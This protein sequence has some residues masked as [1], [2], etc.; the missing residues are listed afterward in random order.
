MT[1][2][3]EIQVHYYYRLGSYKDSTQ[4]VVVVTEIRPEDNAFYDDHQDGGWFTLS[5][6]VFKYVDPAHAREHGIG[7]ESSEYAR[8]HWTLLEDE[9]IDEALQDCQTR[10]RQ[11]KA[12]WEQQDRLSHQYDC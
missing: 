7:W 4:A 5:S 11:L 8:D 10:E 12:Y 6:V 1:S 9:Q 3:Q 2:K